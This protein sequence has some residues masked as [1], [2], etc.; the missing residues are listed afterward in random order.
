M[1]KTDQKRFV[2]ELSLTIATEIIDQIRDGKIPDNW[3]GHQLRVLL[4]RRHQASAS[5]STVLKDRRSKREFEQ[6]CLERNL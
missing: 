5:M 3:D 2:R 4:A 1:T 6:Q